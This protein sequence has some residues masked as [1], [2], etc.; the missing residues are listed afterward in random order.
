MKLYGYYNDNG[1]IKAAEV[2]VKEKVVLI[3]ENEG[4]LIPFIYGNN[5]D[6]EKIGET[7]ERGNV[8]FYKEPSFEHAKEQFLDKTK[9]DYVAT[10]KDYEKVKTILET[11]E[12]QEV[13][14]IAD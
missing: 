2:K 8:I 9:K 3:P 5:I 7:I 13:T 12:K 10:K 11:L 6:P 1:E 14:E 4:D